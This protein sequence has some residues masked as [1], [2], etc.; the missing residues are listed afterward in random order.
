M[1]ERTGPWCHPSALAIT[2]ANDLDNDSP[3]VDFVWTD[4]IDFP[5]DVS[6]DYNVPGCSC[7]PTCDPKSKPCSCTQR[8]LEYSPFRNNADSFV[9]EAIEAQVSVEV[10]IT[11]L[12]DDAHDPI[13]E[14]NTSCKCTM[15]CIN[16]VR[17][18][19]S[20]LDNDLDTDTNHYID[21][22]KAFRSSLAFAKGGKQRMGYCDRLL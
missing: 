3:P 10:P 20:L 8:A 17:S 22:T 9:Y 19:H 15:S 2:I 6:L 16:R 12:S 11:R 13:V 18:S 4:G 5:L 7:F 1:K 14:C 21:R